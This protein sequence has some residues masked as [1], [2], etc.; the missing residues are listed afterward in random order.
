MNSMIH[1]E[2]IRNEHRPVRPYI[3]GWPVI[4]PKRP[5]GR[6]RVRGRAALS[7]ARMA[8]RIDDRAAWRA[9]AP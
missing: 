1:F 5:P 8:R 4:R 7:L 2:A 6:R 3:E 9:F